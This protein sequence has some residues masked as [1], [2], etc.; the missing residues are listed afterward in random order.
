MYDDL[1][2]NYN[3]QIRPV[4]KPSDNIKLRLGIKLSQLSDIVIFSSFFAILGLKLFNFQLLNKKKDERNQIMTTNVIKIFI[5][6]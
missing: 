4:E 3:S 2:S 1:L 5:R 6:I